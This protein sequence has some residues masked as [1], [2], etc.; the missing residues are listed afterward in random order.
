MKTRKIGRPKKDL[1]RT[2]I[3]KLAQ[4][5]CTYEE[6]ASFFD[7]DKSTISR[8]Y[9]TE[10]TKGRGIGKISLRRKQYDVAMNGN[11]TLLIWLGKQYLGQKEPERAELEIPPGKTL[12]I[13]DEL[14]DIA[15]NIGAAM[16]SVGGAAVTPSNN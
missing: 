7:V 3:V 4:L 6:I 16:V 2:Q 14:I 11:P 13:E 5:Q 9:A 10:V 15:K 12:V 8:N 1:D